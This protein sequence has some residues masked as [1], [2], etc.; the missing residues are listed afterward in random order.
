VTHPSD[1]FATVLNGVPLSTRVDSVHPRRQKSEFVAELSATD[2]DDGSRL[3][4]ALAA[5]RL[6]HQAQRRWQLLRMM[7]IWCVG[8]AGFWQLLRIV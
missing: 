5:E 7:R 4:L 1:V 8:A 6:R 2:Y 3:T